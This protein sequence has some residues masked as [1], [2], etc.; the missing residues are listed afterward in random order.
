MGSHR[1]DSSWD[2]SDFFPSMPVS[3]T[4]NHHH[5]G[6]AIFERKITGARVVEK[7]IPGYR[8]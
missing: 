3:L 6:Y 1:F 8:A 5:Q 4:E 2:N 7:E